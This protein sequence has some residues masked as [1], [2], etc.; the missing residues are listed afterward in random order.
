MNE[1]G[2]PQ[3]AG[4]QIQREEYLKHE[5]LERCHALDG[6]TGCEWQNNECIIHTLPVTVTTG[7]TWDS[8]HQCIAFGMYS[9][10]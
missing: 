3:T 10:H 1:A 2:V 6:A 9:S 4:V 5:C 7:H 8:E